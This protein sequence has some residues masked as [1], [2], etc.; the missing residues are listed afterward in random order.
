MFDLTGK[1]AVVTGG[2][3][4]IGEA[5]ARALAKQGAKVYVTGATS[6]EKCKRVTDSI[7]AEGGC[8][9]PI[10]CDLSKPGAA[11]EMHRLTGDA[12]IL[13]LNA[14][15]QF[16]NGWRT[17]TSDEIDTQLTVNFKASF[18]AIQQYEPY[19]SK[20]KW[21]RIL[22]VGSV[23]QYRPH[24]DMAIYAA[25]K[26]AQMSIVKNLAKQVAENGVTI[27]NLSPGAIATPRNAEALADEEYAKKVYAGIPMGYAGEAEDMVG[28]ALLLC[29]D[30]GRYITGTDLI[31]DGGMS[32]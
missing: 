12:D 31:V 32:L 1:V 17:I 11:K 29:S 2:S 23:Q 4:G 18:E 30:E 20:N 25:S 7:N 19:M 27:N 9:E 5:I 14:S 15:V 26:C 22:T 24:K 8:A 6:I 28:A 13:V 10:V 3:Q 16:R 21:G